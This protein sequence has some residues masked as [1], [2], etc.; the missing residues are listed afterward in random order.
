MEGRST[1]SFSFSST[2][3][4]FSSTSSVST[5]SHVGSLIPLRVAVLIVRDDAML[6]A[7]K[8]SALGR[9]GRGNFGEGS[10]SSLLFSKGI[11]S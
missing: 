1:F 11:G 4:A 5:G 10:S 9:A 7:G 3:R 6:E 8:G 2:L